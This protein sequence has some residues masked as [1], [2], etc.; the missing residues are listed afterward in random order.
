MAEPTRNFQS[1][2]VE[3]GQIIFAAGDSGSHAYL[4]SS[5]EIELYTMVDGEKKIHATMEPGEIL[6]EMA[7][8]TGAPRSA[9]AAATQPTELL[10]IDE[11]TLQMV[12]NRS[13]PL[14]KALMNQLIA[15]IQKTEELIEAR[16]L[17]ESLK[18]RD[19]EF[20]G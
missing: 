15:R 13:V 1:L 19:S 7:I 4:I 14:V 3:S 5:G 17:D 10:I 16:N 11:A 9:T 6:G 20:P 18:S 8:I 12:L 2:K